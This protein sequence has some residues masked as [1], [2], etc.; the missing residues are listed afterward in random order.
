MKITSHSGVRIFNCINIILN[1]DILVNAKKYE[2]WAVVYG[3]GIV[4]QQICRFVQIT[5]RLLVVKFNISLIFCLLT[6]G[7]KTFNLMKLH[8][9]VFKFILFFPSS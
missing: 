4:T 5:F 7:I 8:V 1:C 3:S 6:N 9:S 2:Y